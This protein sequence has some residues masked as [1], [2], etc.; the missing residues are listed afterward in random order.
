[1]IEALIFMGIGAVIYKI[2]RD[3]K[4]KPENKNTTTHW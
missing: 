4:D 3:N 1:M 2:Y